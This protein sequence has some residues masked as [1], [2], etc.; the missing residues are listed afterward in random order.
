MIRKTLFTA[1]LAVMSASTVPAA[2]PDEA[3]QLGK[4]LTPTGAEKAGNKDGT[5]PEWTGG[6]T[7][8]PP[9]FKP[10]STT[11]APIPSRAT[12]RAW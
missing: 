11:Y 3:A 2:T 12:S 10:G 4:T 5:I 9:G 8:S 6:L 1:I 7:T